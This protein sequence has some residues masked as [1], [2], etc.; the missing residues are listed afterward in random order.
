MRIEEVVSVN[1]LQRPAETEVSITISFGVTPS[2]T[3]FVHHRRPRTSFTGH[4]FQEV[5]K[6]V[7][8]FTLNNNGT[9]V[10]LYSTE[11][12]NGIKGEGE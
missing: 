7:A 5:T 10:A 1:W 8:V 12:S 9:G 3:N 4:T 6:K 11:A 2:M